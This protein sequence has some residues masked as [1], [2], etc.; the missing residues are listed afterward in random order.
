MH[1][2]TL[3]RLKSVDSTNTWAKE[4]YQKRLLSAN[5]V[6]VAET[7]QQGRGQQ[8]TKWHDEPGKNLLFTLVVEPKKLPVIDFFKL[9]MVVSLALHKVLSEKLPVS[10][11]WPNDIVCE[12]KKLAGILIETVVSG[13]YIKSAFI[14][15]GLNV[16]QLHF[17]Q[18]LNAASLM[19]LTGIEVDHEELLFDLLNS[20]HEY[21]SPNHELDLLKEYNN[22]LYGKETL[23]PFADVEGEFEAKVIKVDSDGILNLR[24]AGESKPRK[25]RFKEVRWLATNE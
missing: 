7:Q 4:A 1:P 15:V 25:Y 6:I 10:V 8:L 14:G 9:N 13:V 21:L 16:N 3:V 19:S 22:V 11:K 12:S 17:S 2:Y 23:L 24:V 20:L 5:A 18:S